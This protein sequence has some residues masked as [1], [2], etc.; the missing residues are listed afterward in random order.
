MISDLISTP[1]GW[2]KVRFGDIARN[3]T[4]RIDNPKESGLKDYI[5]LDHLDTDE[6]RIKRFGSTDDVE[7]TKFLCKKGDIIF[8]KRNAYLRKVAVTDRDAV[9]SAHSM[10]LRPKDDKIEPRFLPCFMQSSQ[11]WKTAQ[12]ISEGSMS[13]T[14]KWKTLSAQEFWLPSRNEQR[15]IAEILWSIEFNLERLEQLTQ[16][17]EKLKKGLLEE[18]VTK[19]INQGK[20]KKTELGEI[21]EEW[22][23]AKLGELS[24]RITKGTT[25]TTYGFE[26]VDEGINFIK[27]ESID[28]D[29][30]FLPT[31]FAHIEQATNSALERSILEKDDILFSIAGALGRVAIVKEDILPA[32]TNQ[33]VGIIRLPRNKRISPDFLKLYLVS[34]LVKEYIDKLNVKTAQANLSLSILSDIPVVVPDEFS[35][36]KIVQI[37]DCTSHYC[38]SLK[39]HLEKL[40][41]LK[42]KLTNSFLSGE[43]LIPKE[44]MN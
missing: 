27:V 9:V 42:K 28:E 30:N 36:K 35:Q 22:E 19:G 6:I 37:A 8:G 7:A 15:K 34:N 39:A 29:G 44:A 32:N 31:Q 5:G 21:P 38:K 23:I 43:L 2:E 13:P 1:P 33:A 16:V 18:L 20:F 26:F 3:V 10:V 4:D 14:I 24:E 17:T 41:Y 11:F 40:V 25:P 12:A